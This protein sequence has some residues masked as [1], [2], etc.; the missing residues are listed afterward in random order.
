MQSDEF[1][2]II[3]NRTV[4]ALRLL[5]PVPKAN[6][7]SPLHWYNYDRLQSSP[8]RI[9]SDTYLEGVC[10]SQ[11]DT[12]ALL[13]QRRSVHGNE[14]HECLLA[15][16]YSANAIGPVHLHTSLSLANCR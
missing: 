11:A 9:Y 7:C 8:L 10:M 3:D 14:Q 2:T 1:L 4:S 6:C 13:V 5:L 12:L 16:P 15:L